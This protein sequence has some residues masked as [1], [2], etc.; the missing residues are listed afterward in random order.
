MMQTYMEVFG[1]LPTML[2]QRLV[3]RPVRMSDAEDMY[4]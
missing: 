3:L 4:E 2:T 1:H